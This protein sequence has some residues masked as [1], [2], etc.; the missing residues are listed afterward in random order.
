M[1]KEPGYLTVGKTPLERV[2]K[3][4]SKLHSISVSKDRGSLISKEAQVLLNK[5][6]QQVVSIFNNL[7]KPLKLQSFLMN[8]L[9]LLTDIPSIVQTVSVKHGLN[10]DLK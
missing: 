7:L 2:R 9:I 3:L 8:D 10:K 1:G 6:I 4:L 5:F